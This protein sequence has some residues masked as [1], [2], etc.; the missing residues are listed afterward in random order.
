VAASLKAS[1]K[2]SLAEIK[3][4]L[5]KEP[6]KSKKIELAEKSKEEIKKS[7]ANVIKVYYPQKKSCLDN[8]M[9]EITKDTSEK[10]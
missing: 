5:P 2:A 9:T 10:D 4:M 8:S 3:S 7:L 6:V 1:P